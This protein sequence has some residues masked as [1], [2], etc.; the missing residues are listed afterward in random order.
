M[1]KT[2]KLVLLVVLFVGAIALAVSLNRKQGEVDA[3]GPLA[4]AEDV[5]GKDASKPVHEALVPPSP[6][7][8]APSTFAAESVGP[9]SGT[10]LLLHAGDESHATA[11]VAT[12]AVDGPVMR[13]EPESDP[14]QPILKERTGLRPSF[15]DDYMVY[16]VAAGDTWNTLAQRFYQDERFIRNLQQANDDLV[17]L[18]AGKEILVPLFDFFQPAAGLQAD[19]TPVAA[20]TDRK[21]VA[22]PES[23]APSSAPSFATRTPSTTTAVYEVQ[24]GDT[25][26]DISLAVFGTATRWKEIY[27]ANRDQLK[28][29]EWLQV[30]MKLKLPAGAQAATRVAKTETKPAKTEPKAAASDSKAAASTAKKKKVL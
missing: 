18:E 10:S 4:A 22:K 13:S 2:E 30:G 12:S 21:P 23:A 6:S 28:T 26:S 11:P 16:T 15:L 8:T 1:G 25:L 7:S 17:A 24:S 27:E 14:S 19:T 3:S 20:L 5:L 29:P 9:E